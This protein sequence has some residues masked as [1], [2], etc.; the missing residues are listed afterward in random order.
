[1]R[2][3]VPYLAEVIDACEPFVVGQIVVVLGELLNMPGHLVVATRDTGTVYSGYH[4]E[5]FRRLRP[6]ET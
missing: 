2:T 6:D 1:M 3:K 5:R 4:A